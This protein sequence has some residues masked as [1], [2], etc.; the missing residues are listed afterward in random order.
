MSGSFWPIDA[1]H[2]GQ[3]WVVS[4]HSSMDTFAAQLCKRLVKWNA[5]RWSHRMQTDGHVGA[6]IQRVRIW[7]KM[8][9]PCRFLPVHQRQRSATTGLSP[10]QS[11][12]H[13]KGYFI[14]IP[15]G[16]SIHACRPKRSFSQR[17]PRGRIAAQNR[18]LKLLRNPMGQH[19]GLT[20]FTIQL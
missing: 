12:R 1:P 18:R 17:A 3:L 9:F 13:S 16:W 5:N 10:E 8:T 11:E 19:Y 20:Q 14:L 4:C 15:A 2:Q 7:S 6:V